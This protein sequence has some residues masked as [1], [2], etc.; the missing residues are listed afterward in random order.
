MNTTPMAAVGERRAA[1]TAR[2]RACTRTCTHSRA[3][4]HA[5][6]RCPSAHRLGMHSGTSPRAACAVL[7]AALAGSALAPRCHASAASFAPPPAATAHAATGPAAAYRC[8][9]LRRVLCVRLGARGGQAQS[10]RAPRGCRCW[11]RAAARL[12]FHCP[13]ESLASISVFECTSFE[14]RGKEG[15]LCPAGRA[16]T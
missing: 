12:C 14:R 11:A 6:T 2:V 4:A 3:R 8:V 10:V 16:D 1:R 13:H 15:R 5:H 7:A 9:R